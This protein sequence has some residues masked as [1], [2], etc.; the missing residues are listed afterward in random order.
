MYYQLPCVHAHFANSEP[1][2]PFV[3]YGCALPGRT[4]AQLKDSLH[5]IVTNSELAEETTTKRDAFIRD[6]I[7]KGNIDDLVTFITN[8]L[9]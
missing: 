4:A 6:F 9:T 1:V 3:D 5:H 2:L 7:P 8:N